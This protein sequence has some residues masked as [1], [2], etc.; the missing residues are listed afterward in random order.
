M[1]CVVVAYRAEVVLVEVDCAPGQVD[2]VD[3][4][5]ATLAHDASA[6]RRRLDQHGLVLR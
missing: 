4:I 2:D 3:A 1:C 6:K 5:C